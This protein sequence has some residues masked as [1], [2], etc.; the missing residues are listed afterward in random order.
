MSGHKSEMR[1]FQ[2][3]G[4]FRIARN[5]S[6]I[7]AERGDHFLQADFPVLIAAARLD[8]FGFAYDSFKIQN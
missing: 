8:Y 3:S 2:P 1:V 7:D 5:P 4:L 6:R